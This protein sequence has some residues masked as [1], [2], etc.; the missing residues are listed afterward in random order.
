MQVRHE[1]LDMARFPGMEPLR[2]LSGPYHREEPA[3]RAF[4]VVDNEFDKQTSW[5]APVRSATSPALKTP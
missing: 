5:C 1:L 2:H 3:G 4:G